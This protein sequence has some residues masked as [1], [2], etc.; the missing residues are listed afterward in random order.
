MKFFS[1]TNEINHNL[2]DQKLFDNIFKLLLSE[3]PFDF[4]YSQILKL[5]QEILPQKWKD[6]FLLTAKYYITFAYLLFQ[7]ERNKLDEVFILYNNIINIILERISYYSDDEKQLYNDD[8][9]YLL[10]KSYDWL[11]MLL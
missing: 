11:Y 7:K 4:Y 3:T 10:T 2:A 1:K 8:F 6:D 9:I 5:I